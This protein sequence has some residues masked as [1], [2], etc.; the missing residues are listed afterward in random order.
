MKNK[1]PLSQYG[2]DEVI[3]ELGEL[4]NILK[5]LK[6]GLP[7]AEFQGDARHVVLSSMQT[8]LVPI[9]FCLRTIEYT[10]NNTDRELLGSPFKK[11]TQEILYLTD[12][13]LIG[14]LLTSFHFQIEN[15][16]SNLLRAIKP[17]SQTRGFERITSELFLLITITD[18]EHKKRTLKV[19]SELRNGFHNNGVH[20][21]ADFSETIDGIE[22]KFYKGKAIERSSTFNTIALLKYILVIIEEIYSSP[23]V[24]VLPTPI[25][26]T[27]NTQFGYPSEEEF[28]SQPL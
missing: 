24:L 22:F 10:A 25:I 2:I 3:A 6:T 15:F 18:I 4:I 27:L 12:K 21:N 13:F 8:T 9:V 19:L 20:N 23:E 14:S 16:F 1:E 28:L 26:D 5:R 7:I 17:T 11:S